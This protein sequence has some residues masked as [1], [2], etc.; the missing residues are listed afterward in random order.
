M[1]QIAEVVIPTMTSRRI[2][3]LDDVK[4]WIA[5]HDGRNTAYWKAQHELN[6][7]ADDKLNV[8]DKRL[9]AVEKRVMW[10]A[11]VFAAV[12]AVAG[13]IFSQILSNTP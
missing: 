5:E 11:G 10:I 9:M 7:K 3:D 6:D 1:D 2:E 8:F 12:G 4:T 13:T